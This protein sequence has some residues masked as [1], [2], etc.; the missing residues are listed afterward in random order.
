MQ[1]VGMKDAATG[2]QTTGY[3]KG[4]FSHFDDNCKSLCYG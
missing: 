1:A 4:S 3:F 2:T